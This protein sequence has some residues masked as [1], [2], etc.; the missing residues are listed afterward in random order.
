MFIPDSSRAEDR[1]HF[2]PNQHKG[3]SKSAKKALSSKVVTV[4]TVR[5]TEVEEK[6]I[7]FKLPI[8]KLPTNKGVPIFD[9]M[10]EEDK[11]LIQRANSKVGKNSS[12]VLEEKQLVASKGN[13]N[14]GKGT[15]DKAVKPVT[16]QSSKSLQ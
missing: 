4:K 5:P 16:V 13:A 3:Q 9:S 2:D 11:K 1:I 15:Q 10:F 12:V 14:H 6:E 7:S 8:K